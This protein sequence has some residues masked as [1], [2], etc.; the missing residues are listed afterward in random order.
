VIATFKDGKMEC[1]DLTSSLKGDLYVTGRYGFVEFKGK[2]YKPYKNVRYWEE[3]YTSKIQL[4]VRPKEKTIE[5]LNV[6]SNPIKVLSE[7][8]FKKW[9]KQKEI[10]VDLWT[11]G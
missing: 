3:I 9:K 11:C 5:I 1:G 10:F 6:R 4:L 2:T 8:E 7:K